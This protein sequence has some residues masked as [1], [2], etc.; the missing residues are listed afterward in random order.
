MSKYI[1]QSVS[2]KKHENTHKKHKHYDNNYVPL[3]YSK[4]SSIWAQISPEDAFS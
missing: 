3:I 1:Q 2:E 4:D